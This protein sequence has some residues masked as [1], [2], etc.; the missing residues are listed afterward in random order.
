MDPCSNILSKPIWWGPPIWPP[1]I[2][3]FFFTCKPFID[4]REKTTKRGFG[5]GQRSHHTWP[6]PLCCDSI[7]EISSFPRR[8]RSLTVWLPF[9]F[10]GDHSLSP[11]NTQRDCIHTEQ[12]FCFPVIRFLI[13]SRKHFVHN[14]IFMLRISREAFTDQCVYSN[15][16][17]FPAW[18]F[19]WP[20]ELYNRINLV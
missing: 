14:F 1:H 3:F 12:Y 2:F 10:R 19:T 20:V 11:Q 13:W 7:M 8:Q 4:G 9:T 6:K 17:F 16:V 15:E 5:T 18:L